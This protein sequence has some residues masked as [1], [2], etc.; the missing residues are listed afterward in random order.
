M[1][2]KLEDH[3]VPKALQTYYPTPPRVGVRIAGALQK[4]LQGSYTH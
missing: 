2:P 1:T 3:L 4:H